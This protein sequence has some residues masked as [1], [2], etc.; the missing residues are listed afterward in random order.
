MASFLSTKISAA[1]VFFPAA[2]LQGAITVLL[3]VFIALSEINHPSGLVG[4]GHG[5]EMLFGFAL[6]L[7]AGYT[8][9]PTPR[10]Q[11]GL[12]LGLWLAAR[13]SF[14]FFP[15]K[16][17][18]QLLSPAFALLLIWYVFPRFLAAKKWRNKMISPLLLVICS[19]PAI[20]FILKINGWPLSP[21][22]LVLSL[23]LLLTLLM[24]FMGGRIIAPAAAGECYKQGYNLKARV[25]P[26]LEGLLILILPVTALMAFI[27]GENRI[28]GTLALVA[29][30][31]LAIRL[32][33]WQLWRCKARPDLIG[34]GV[35]YAW[36]SIGAVMTGVTLI[37]GQPVAA[38]LHIITVGALGSLSISVIARLHFQRKHRSPPPQ[39][40]I[41]STLALTA[42]AA[43]FRF[44]A[45]SKPYLSPVLLWISAIAW[46][47]AFFW[48]T[49]NL[50]T[51]TSVVKSK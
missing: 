45:G 4:M 3:T 35:G 22:N 11:L 32:Y 6:A 24:S 48:L 28:A 39:S 10:Y 27:P 5:H 1:Q 16:L 38:V 36:L 37:I 21:Q 40:L 17:I 14:L 42:I 51:A 7:I 49:I 18:S 25:Q 34:L 26:R 46:A 33:R 31:I 9:G 43:V 50:I 13:I 2:T 15:E 47:L 8:L 20:W 29:G 44:L 19:F 30:I 23:I 12:L 41:I